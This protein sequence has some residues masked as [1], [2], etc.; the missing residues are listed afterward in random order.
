ME[1]SNAIPRIALLP[2]ATGTAIY[3]PF[4]ALRSSRGQSVCGKPLQDSPNV[5]TKEKSDHDPLL[6]SQSGSGSQKH[7]SSLCLW[8][9]AEVSHIPES[10]S[11]YIASYPVALGSDVVLGITSLLSTLPCTHLA[12]VKLSLR[13]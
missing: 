3:L 4:A 10:L 6:Q 8:S 1:S 11:E 9:A 12:W 2:R 5:V 7:F 13:V